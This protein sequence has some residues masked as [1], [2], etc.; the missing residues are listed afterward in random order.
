MKLEE[1]QREFSESIRAD[2]P[3]HGLPSFGDGLC[4]YRNNYREQLRS[5]LRSAFPYLLL[6]LGH[7][8]FDRV[9]DAHIALHYP[10]SWTLD[11]YGHDLPATVTAL[12]PAD[13]EV[14]ELAW[15]DWMMAEALVAEDEPSVETGGLAELDW[16]N[17]QVIFVRSMRISEARSN[18]AEIWAALEEQTTPPPSTLLA[19]PHGY[20][21][22]RRG[23]LP[24]FRLV[25]IW[26]HQIVSALCH[27]FSFADACEVLR[28]RFGIERA[29]KAAG[30]MLA[31][32]L[33]DELITR[34]EAKTLCRV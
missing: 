18:A 12:F 9:A 14:R 28:L 32:W 20:V 21:V 19:E 2:T 31:R 24:C 22:W 27:G 23:L 1:L 7:S 15:L 6:W 30:E 16:D 3:P 10:D 4:V 17:A 5:T 34:V 25:P 13:P 33:N 26:E 8:E 11:H 29:I